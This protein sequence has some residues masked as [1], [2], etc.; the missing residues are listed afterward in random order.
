MWIVILI[1]D[2]QAIPISVD[3]QAKLSVVFRTRCNSI[4][5]SQCYYLICSLHLKWQFSQSWSFCPFLQPNWINEDKIQL[6]AKQWCINIQGGGW[7][8][9]PTCVFFHPCDYFY[10]CMTF[11]IKL[12]MC[13]FIK[14]ELQAYLCSVV[15]LNF[16]FCNT[17]S[18]L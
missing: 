9:S 6:F 17:I 4:T 1:L 10:W 18:M 2:N 7:I 15:C 11:S 13:V 14:S 3:C 12:H 16:T 5:R 8:N